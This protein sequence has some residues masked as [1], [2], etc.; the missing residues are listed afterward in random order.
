MT[1]DSLKPEFIPGLK[2][3]ADRGLVLDSAN[4][5]LKLIRAIASVSDH[6]PELRIVIDHLPTA[7]S[8]LGSN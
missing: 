5:D 3:L 1:I 2:M 8:A 4:P 7:R 6:V